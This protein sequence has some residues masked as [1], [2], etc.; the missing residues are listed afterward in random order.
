M[1]RRKK[2]Q[3]RHMQLGLCMCCPNI[4]QNG[5]LCS[6]CSDKKKARHNVNQKR[7]RREL[8]SNGCCPCCGISLQHFPGITTKHCPNCSNR[9]YRTFLSSKQ[10][11]KYVEIRNEYLKEIA[12]KQE[13]V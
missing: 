5:Y 3:I 11:Y 10:T 2:Y 4:A 8:I 13:S 12:E 1:D 9:E 7:R 6:S